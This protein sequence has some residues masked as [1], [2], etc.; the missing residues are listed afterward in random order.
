VLWRQ[1]RLFW[2]KLLKWFDD[3]AGPLPRFDGLIDIP[4]SRAS[5]TGSASPPPG[6]PPGPP[7]PA[8]PIRV[9]PLNPDDVQKFNAV[10]DKSETPNGLIS[11]MNGWSV[12]FACSRETD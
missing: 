5:D 2:S 1:I 4:S 6:P 9:P 10:F 3:A 12:R 7:P 8:N 11:G